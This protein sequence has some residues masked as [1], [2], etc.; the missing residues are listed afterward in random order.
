MI[1][2]FTDGVLAYDSRLADYDLLGLVTTTGVNKGGSATITMPPRHPAYNS[3]ISFKTI[4]EI[5]RDGV[6]IFRGRPLYPTDDFLGRRTIICEGERCFLRDAIS[7]PY[8]YQDS[9]EAVFSAVIADYNSQV[10]SFK[11][12]TVGTVTVTDPN[13]YIRIY[14]ETAEQLSD[15][16]DKLV[17]RCGGYVVFTSNNGQRYINWYASLDYRSTQTIEFGENLLDYERSANTD[18]ATRIVPY[19]AKDEETGLRITIESVN[20]GRDYIEDTDAVALRGVITK[21]ILWDDVTIPTNLLHKAQAYL[22]SSKQIITELQLTAVDLSGL[23]QNIDAF[24][25]GDNVHVISRPHGIDDWMLLQDLTEDLLDPANSTISLGKSYSTLTGADVAGDRESLSDMQR[26]DR[27]IREDYTR[28]V[29]TAVNRTTT[30][31]QSLIEQTAESIRLM[32]TE[33]YITGEDVTAQISTAITQLSDSIQFDFNRITQIVDENDEEARAQ[34]QTIHN[35]IRF[36]DGNI[37][38]GEAGNEITLKIEND[39]IGFYDNGAKVAYLSDKKLYVTSGEFINSL[40]LGKFA[41]LP[42]ENGNLS[43]KKVVD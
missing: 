30:D 31:L 39:T 9:P 6:L 15:T 12:F 22:S 10:D 17:E 41:F 43:F 26:I 40:Q 28:D 20:E 35:Y 33:S 2:I 25:V 19:G 16:I 29:T 11:Q 5:Y 8:E 27:D 38:L 34:F 3:F 4:V 18:I 23:G 32:V 36:E 7:R 1:Q 42:R 13:D 14:T 37:L 21:P 24:R